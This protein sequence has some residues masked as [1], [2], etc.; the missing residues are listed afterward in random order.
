M[1]AARVTHRVQRLLIAGLA[2]FVAWQVAALAGAP[3]QVQVVLGLYG[4][5]F[6]VVFAKAYSLLPS[7][8]A[9]EL[10][11]PWAPA[12]QLPLAGV[13]VAG[14]AAAGLGAPTVVGTVG[15]GLWFAGV[16]VFLGSLI[17]TIRDNPLGMDSGTGEAK[18][19]RRPVDQYANAF[20]PIVLVYLL[21]SAYDLLAVRVGAPTVAG[22]PAT[23]HLL[24]AGAGA[25]LVFAVGF[26]L[27]P[28][29]LVASP[30]RVLVMVVLPAG[31]LGPVL[32]AMDFLGGLEFRIGAALEAV[33]IVGF[34]TGLAVLFARSDRRRVGGYA[35]LSGAAAGVLGV[36]LGLE[37]AFRGVP[38]GL[39]DAH[40]RLNLLGFLGLTIVGVT[41]HMYPP[42]AGRFPWAGDRT[43]LATVVLL[44]GGLALEVLGVLAGGTALVTGGR[45]AAL[46]GAIGYGYLIVGLLRQQRAR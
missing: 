2:F 20:V 19:D 22:G 38:V 26:R 18:A 23:T 4:F 10:A 42:G 43:A 3:R 41:Y 21:A 13:G 29:L 6:H 15:A 28:R 30:P 46:A 12:V 24:A 45:I 36:G 11:V 7:Y 39:V 34:A 16:V 5:V 31:A 40:A 33:A 44:G 27:L 14:L 25:L 32:L 17:W 37:F 8:F 35:V 9:R 1:S